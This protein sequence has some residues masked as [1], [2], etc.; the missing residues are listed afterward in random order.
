MGSP[1]GGHLLIQGIEGTQLTHRIAT[2]GLGFKVV[3]T[4]DIFSRYVSEDRSASAW[5]GHITYPFDGA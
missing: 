1:P 3:D 2:G 5:E 4:S